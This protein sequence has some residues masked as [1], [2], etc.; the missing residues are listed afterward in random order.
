MA[1]EFSTPDGPGGRFTEVSPGSLPP[2][3]DAITNTQPAIN[4]RFGAGIN[5]KP[6]VNRTAAWRAQLQKQVHTIVAPVEIVL[7]SGGTVL[8]VRPHLLLMYRHKVF[9][10]ALTPL[11]E[12]LI[13]NAMGDDGTDEN[14]EF[15]AK[16]FEENSVEAYDQF[17]ELL[18]YVWVTAVIDPVFVIDLN[19][20]TSDAIARVQHLPVEER[21]LLPVDAVELD[22]KLFLFNW[23]QGVTDDVAA[24]RQRQSERMAALQEKQTMEDPSVDAPRTRSAR[25]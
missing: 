22:D 18:N 7:P 23:C 4:D 16:Q 24:F 15:I 9:P 5:V 3:W 14:D 8:A 12:K 25:G 17:M 10:N 20:P 21:T 2:G 1:P 11:I 6:T 19:A 13:K